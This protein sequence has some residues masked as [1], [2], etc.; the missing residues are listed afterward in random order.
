MRRLS[1]RINQRTS[2]CLQSFMALCCLCSGGGRERKSTLCSTGEKRESVTLRELDSIYSTEQGSCVCWYCQSVLYQFPS[3]SR[4][5]KHT[6]MC[7]IFFPIW[8]SVNYFCFLK[9]DITC[10]DFRCRVYESRWTERVWASAS[11]CDSGIKQ[12]LQLA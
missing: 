10:D 2:L 6:V 3:L 12:S 9:A 1:G 8:E 11:C 4:V 5:T 7:Y